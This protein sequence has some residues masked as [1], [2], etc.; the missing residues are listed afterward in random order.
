MEKVK[1]KVG[2]KRVG[3][4]RKKGSIASKGINLDKLINANVSF[5]K[6]VRQLQEQAL[7]GDFKSQQ[8]LL[9]YG[10]GK[11]KEMQIVIT[12]DV[13]NK[14]I[15]GAWLVKGEDGSIG[16]IDN[17]FNG[18]SKVIEDAEIIEDEDG[19]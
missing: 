9:A 12:E 16:Y 3:A 7:E 5:P 17:N 1:S 6:I 8:L 2:G 13:T 14:P 10:F 15:K 18:G 11:P 19:E 4:G